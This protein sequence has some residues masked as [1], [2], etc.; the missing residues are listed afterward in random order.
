MKRK[1]TKLQLVI[2]GITLIILI[3]MF[4]YIITMWGNIPE[5]IP[6]HYNFA[7]EVDRWGNKSEILIYPII[8]LVLYVLLVVAARFPAICNIPIRIT[9]DNR[10]YVYENI[11]SMIILLKM[12]LMIMFMYMMISGLKT[13]SLGKW[14]IPMLII[15]QL[16][17][18]TYY[19]IRMYSGN[20]DRKKY[21]E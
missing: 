18:L 9:D 1:H 5:Q 7:G 4:I 17:T 11:K 21:K 10:E 14:F 13:Q 8:S 6:G 12:E 2:E 3:S 15:V 20:K 19:L 16:C